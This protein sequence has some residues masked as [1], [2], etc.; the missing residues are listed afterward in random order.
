MSVIENALRKLRRTAGPAGAGHAT[1]QRSIN[2]HAVLPISPVDVTSFATRRIAVDLSR[3]RAEGYLPAPAR[4]RLLA[5]CYREIKR[6][7]IQRAIAPESTA[8]QRVI[9]I[10]S[11]LPGEGKTFTSVNLAL[12][13]AREHDVC[14]L[15]VDADLAMS[16]VSRIFGIRDEPGLLNALSDDSIDAESLVL[17]T[18]IPGLEIMASGAGNSTAGSPERRAELIAS[19]RMNQVADQLGRRNHRRL[20]LM[21]SPPVL[22]SSEARALLR[23]PGQILLVTRSGQTPQQALVDAIAAVDK[24][25]LHGLV[26]N[27]AN[28]SSGNPYYYGHGYANYAARRDENASEAEIRD[29]N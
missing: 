22:V 18:D 17:H 14:V 21:D 9:M 23:I 27:D 4:E 8:E 29:A 20:V 16:E 15:L 10:S 24:H 13:I 26:L 25:R 1:S 2:A 11:A 3:L 6:P 7:V 28:L 12:S 5:D 19:C